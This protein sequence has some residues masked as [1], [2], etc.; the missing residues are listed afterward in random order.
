[1]S[2]TQLREPASSE[3]GDYLRVLRSRRWTTIRVVVA[4]LAAT[5]VFTALQH[6]TYQASTEVLLTS[7]SA[8]SAGSGAN[9]N[10]GDLNT[11]KAIVASPAV[12]GKVKENLGLSVTTTALMN[13]VKVN[14]PSGATVLS[15]VYTDGDP[16]QAAR[17]ADAFADA[18]LTFRADQ[19]QVALGTAT[20]S[21]RS[22][23]AA[24][25]V[26]IAKISKKLESVTAGGTTTALVNRRLSL[27]ATLIDLQAKLTVV[28]TTVQTTAKV[29][30]P[31][32]V[33]AHPVSPS[34]SRNLLAAAIAGLAV[35]VILAFAGDALDDRIRS[36]RELQQ[37]SGVP[38]LAEIPRVKAWTA[39]EDPGVHLIRSELQ[40]SAGREAYN[41]LGTNVLYLSTKQPAQTLM[42]T[43]AVAG[44][45]TTTTVANLGVTLAGLG[46]SVCLVDLNLA[47][48][49]LHR[50]FGLGGEVGLSS[51]LLDSA[52]LEEAMTETLIRNLHLVSGG[53]PVDADKLAP[54]FR[55]GTY[56]DRLRELHDFVIL[57]T[58]AI[59]SAEVASII[60]P[61]IDGALVVVNPTELSSS[62]FRS[63]LRTLRNSGTSILG[64]VQNGLNGDR[65]SY[66]QTLKT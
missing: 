7:S 22:E 59:G 17:I 8:T 63:A 13:H 47:D 2:T 43:S 19:A 54:V 42:V 35:G 18:Y 40:K 9:N 66:G 52:T 53:G 31:A 30:R 25:E 32:V 36:R 51:V 64:T 21:L 50:V 28:S 48:P 11:E 34:W 10:V 14:A 15:I 29:I 6:P 26:E 3:I 27:R 65:A 24:V 20:A 44:E 62:D 5:I 46:R 61:V 55:D 16:A 49:A 1:M 33:P 45:G 41:A 38:T 60:G 4:A 56:L 58:P 39:Q 57:D 37:M 23:I 12:A